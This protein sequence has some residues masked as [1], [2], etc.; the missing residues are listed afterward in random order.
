[1]LV[2]LASHNGAPWI[3]QQLDSILTQ[4]GVDV[5]VAIR[6][7]GSSDRTLEE[8][9]GCQAGARLRLA[10]GREPTG[11][12]AQNFL[13]LV[14]QNPGEDCEFVAF[15]DQDDLWHP[16][17]LLRACRRLTETGSS[18]YSSAT[19]ATWPAGRKVLLRQSGALTK[20]DFLFE[21]AGQGCTFVLRADFYGR[22]RAF[23]P[24]HPHLTRR[25]HYH[26]WMFY[27]LARSWGCRWTF[28]PWPSVWYRQHAGNDTGARGSWAAIRKRVALMKS[29]WYRAQIEAVAATC[30]AAAPENRIVR[31]WTSLL[32]A[33]RGPLRRL[34]ITLFCLF[35][36]RRKRMDNAALTLAA[37]AGWI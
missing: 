15:A 11:S 23:L 37:L 27:A 24:A 7:D 32:A 26:D 14:R 9:A 20:G 16:E 4:S 33:R 5:C 35:A 25:I 34:R 13:E 3:R 18:G 10:P 36:G 31:K 19:L 8:I 12:A 6:D 30:A 1:M 29:G 22:V 28:D 2:L 21:G 17:K